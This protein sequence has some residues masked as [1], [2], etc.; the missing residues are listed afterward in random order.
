MYY[1]DNGSVFVSFLNILSESSPFQRVAQETI[2]SL[3]EST[4]VCEI[5]KTTANILSKFGSL[6]L[7]MQKPTEVISCFKQPSLNDM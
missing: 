5:Y 4:V 6:Y 1:K 7:I 3:L 2:V